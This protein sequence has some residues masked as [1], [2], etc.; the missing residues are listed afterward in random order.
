MVSY[1]NVV[2]VVF[3]L[4]VV[5]AVIV[6]TPVVGVASTYTNTFCRVCR[7]TDSPLTFGY[8]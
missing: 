6:D 7:Q 5:V 3:W 8:L 1:K 2:V 4:V